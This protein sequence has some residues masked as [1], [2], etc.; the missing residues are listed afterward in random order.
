LE[1]DR[2]VSRKIAIAAAL[3]SH[4]VLCAASLQA[5]PASYVGVV[6]P[7][8][9]PVAC[10]N[11]RE[12]LI[13]PNGRVEYVTRQECTPGAATTGS[14][15]RVIRERVILPNGSVGYISRNQC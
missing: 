12:R 6:T 5:A 7:L 4:A 11:V 2:A 9:E 3:F 15:C 1:A 13:L 14:G 10:R 8:A